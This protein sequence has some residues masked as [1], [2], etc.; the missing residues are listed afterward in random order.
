MPR[1]MSGV[2][3]VMCEYQVSI[4]YDRTHISESVEIFM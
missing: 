3:T 2:S 4:N 1:E